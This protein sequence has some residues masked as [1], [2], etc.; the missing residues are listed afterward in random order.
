MS[1]GAQEQAKYEEIWQIPA[2]GDTSPGE[3]YAS[4]FE[5]LCEPWP[6]ASVVDLGCGRG[7]GGRRLEESLELE[8]SFVDLVK[9]EGA[10]GELIQ[11]ALWVPLPRRWNF[12]YCCDVMEH[13]P[14]Q[15]TMLA[16]RNMLDACQHGVFFSIAFFQDSF[17]SYI[18]KPLHLTVKP[19]TWWR[20]SLR[21][22]GEVV[23]ARDLLGEGVFY[24]R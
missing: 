16:A 1:I 2:Y 21:E 14:E 23:E 9:A 24:V 5:E 15:F 13:L 12:G 19:F 6:G 11:Q 8:V 10:P 17:G 22:I 7:D 18:H 4:K 3:R 20:D